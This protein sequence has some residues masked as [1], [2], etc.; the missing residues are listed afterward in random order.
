VEGGSSGST[1]GGNSGSSTSEQGG[2]SSARPLPPQKTITKNAGTADELK[3]PFDVIETSLEIDHYPYATFP[4]GINHEQGLSM[5]IGCGKGTDS[6]GNTVYKHAG[7][8]PVCPALEI[9]Q[10][11]MVDIEN[12]K[13]QALLRSGKSVTNVAEFDAACVTGAGSTKKAPSE[14]E[15]FSPLARNFSLTPGK[16]ENLLY[17]YADNGE[18]A[19]CYYKAGHELRRGIIKRVGGR[20]TDFIGFWYCRKM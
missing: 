19:D 4:V 17:G 16:R 1:S 13:C 9:G 5:V 8:I 7:P 10:R 18:A 14:Y 12:E 6:N 20:E 11:I 15:S 3:I 2:G